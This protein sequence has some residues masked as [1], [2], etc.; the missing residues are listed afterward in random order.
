MLRKIIEKIWISLKK[1]YRRI[2][3]EIKCRFNSVP[4]EPPMTNAIISE[5][6]QE[7]N[8]E[9]NIQK[10]PGILPIISENVPEHGM[11]DWYNINYGDLKHK[12]N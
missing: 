7:N 11:S 6:N 4:S 8:R 9:F 3:I 1:I 2:Y 10:I 12:I 5:N